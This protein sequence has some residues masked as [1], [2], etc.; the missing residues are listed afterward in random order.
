MVAFVGIFSLIAS[1]LVIAIAIFVVSRARQAVP[2]GNAPVYR[3]RKV[4]ATVLITLLVVA[5]ALT[6]GKTP[7]VAYAGERPAMQV[8]VTGHMWTWEIKRAGGAASE[9]LVLPRGK[10]IEF[11]VSSADVN[12]GFGVYD[13]QG[14]LLGQTQAMP[15]YVNHLRMVFDE[16]GSYHVLC[17]E[18]CGLMHHNMLT[19]FSVQ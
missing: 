9:P 14:H 16:P 17:L 4:Y 11:A 19:E 18:Y 12:H 2:N 6:L 3:V 15:G 7:Y 1:L 10:L 13:D 5:L 8:D